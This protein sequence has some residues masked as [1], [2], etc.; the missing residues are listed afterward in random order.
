MPG[1][2]KTEAPEIDATLELLQLRE[3]S[4]SYKEYV[5]AILSK[6]LRPSAIAFLCGE[7]E[8]TMFAAQNDLSL[9][10]LNCAPSHEVVDKR[11]EWPSEYTKLLSF[12][13]AGGTSAKVCPNL[14]HEH[15]L[16][17]ALYAEHRL[18]G[19]VVAERDPCNQPFG[20]TDTEP[21]LAMAPYVAMG[22]WSHIERE[23]VAC[24]ATVLGV[25]VPAPGVLLVADLDRQR[26]VWGMSPN[27][28]SDWRVVAEPI[29]DTVLEAAEEWLTNS[30]PPRSSHGKLPRVVPLRRI[31]EAPFHATRCVLVRVDVAPT[32]ASSL[33][34]REREI[35][36]IL[37]DGYSVTNAAAI[38]ELSENTIRTYVRRLYRKL[39]VT[40]RADLVRTLFTVDRQG[41]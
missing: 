34:E 20:R 23:E 30:K 29:A 27:D 41:H 10:K 17:L 25:L 13:I 1:G 36:V 15:R 8:V 14:A 6:H 32:R 40:N 24:R 5:L 19:L 21:L 26:I 16:F 35:A 12:R 22:A 11:A 7:E 18:F 31:T 38:L 4:T 3:C 37:S 9:R 39:G 33:S 2:T 28:S